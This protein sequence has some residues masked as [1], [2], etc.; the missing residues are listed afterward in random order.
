MC[1]FWISKRPRSLLSAQAL[2]WVPPSFTSDSDDIKSNSKQELTGQEKNLSAT[3]ISHL[4]FHFRIQLRHAI[5]PPHHLKQQLFLLSLLVR[6]NHDIYEILSGYR[7]T[8]LFSPTRSHGI[9]RRIAIPIIDNRVTLLGA[10]VDIDH[11]QEPTTSKTRP[12]P[13]L[14]ARFASP[15]CTQTPPSHPSAPSAPSCTRSPSPGRCS[16]SI[17]TANTASRRSF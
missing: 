4:S 8:P 11:E 17:R 1:I 13:T 5:I 12:I 16:A 7:K 2:F 14:S 10:V 9:N 15:S 3:N 6:L